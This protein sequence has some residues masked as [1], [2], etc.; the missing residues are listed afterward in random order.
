MNAEWH[1]L[2]T[3][4]DDSRGNCFFVVVNVGSRW[5]QQG[6]STF[7]VMSVMYYKV[8]YNKYTLRNMFI[9]IYHITY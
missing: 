2:L 6:M 7:N 5:V 8:I 9:I 4:I 1:D 3:F